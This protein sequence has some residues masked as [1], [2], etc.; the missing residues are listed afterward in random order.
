MP[1]CRKIYADS[2]LVPPQRGLPQKNST[3]ENIMDREFLIESSLESDI[4]IK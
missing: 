2:P 3:L 1:I 4:I